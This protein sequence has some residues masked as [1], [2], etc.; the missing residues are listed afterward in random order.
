MTGVVDPASSL[1][2]YSSSSSFFIVSSLD[3][4]CSVGDV[5]SGGAVTPLTMWSE[6][7]VENVPGQAALWVVYWHLVGPVEDRGCWSGSRWQRPQVML[8]GAGTGK[9]RSPKSANLSASS[10][11]HFK[12]EPLSDEQLPVLRWFGLVLKSK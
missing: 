12:T 1:S 9:L 6:H 3:S 5:D 4:G 11:H 7:F 8:G 10:Q 2:L